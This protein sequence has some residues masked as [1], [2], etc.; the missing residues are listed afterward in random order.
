M[1][2]VTSGQ[3][4]RVHRLSGYDSLYEF[5]IFSII[6]IVAVMELLIISITALL[7]SLLTLISGFGLGTLL[8]PVV[9]IFFPIDIAIAVTAIVHLANNIFKILLLG[10]HANFA[11]V[12]KFGGPAIIFAWF[13]AVVLGWLADLE[14]VFEYSL[15]GHN[16]AVS[17]VKLT[18][19]MLILS[20]IYIELS[21]IFEA[22]T[23]DKKYLPLGG[24]I[25]GFFG[26]L[27]GHQ[28]AFRSMFL[29][30]LGL[31]KESFIA[32]GVTLAVLVDITRISVYGFDMAITAEDIDWPLVVTATLAAFVGAFIG[33]QLIHKMTIKG[34]QVAVSIMLIIVSAGLIGGII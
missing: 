11:V 6:F 5:F 22:N 24:T 28:G 12:L 4:L 25:S 1:T 31:S 13:G 21:K 29:I 20:F 34:V 18:V 17:P 26:G 15:A 30:K 2:S 9:A 27:S 16:F 33:R 14:P 3:R 23:V 32:T 10:R 8:M 19:G 7:A